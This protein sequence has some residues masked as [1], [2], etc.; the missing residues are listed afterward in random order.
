MNCSFLISEPGT[1]GSFC[2]SDS[3]CNDQSPCTL[4][5]C[6]EGVCKSTPTPDESCP[7]VGT[8]YRGTCDALGHCVNEV[9]P[10]EACDDANPCT[11]EE[12]CLNG[13]ACGNGIP[14]DGASCDDLDPCTVNDTCGADGT[15]QAGM[16]AEGQSCEGLEPCT[17][18]N[19]CLLNGS[20]ST[21]NPIAL[22]S[23]DDPCITCSCSSYSGVSCEDLISPECGCKLWGKIKFVDS[24]PDFTIKLVENF[25]DL[26]VTMVDSWADEPGK[27]E[28]VESFEDYRVKIVDSFPDIEV[29]FVDSPSYFCD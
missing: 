27:W 17:K 10:G 23:D 6:V 9:T 26:E 21:G 20:C 22:P 1:P 7:S 5:R 12:V 29:K 25:P 8:C 14:T 13:G 28:E 19:I 3:E 11:S 16:I 15:C 18:D 24:F 4:D 2:T